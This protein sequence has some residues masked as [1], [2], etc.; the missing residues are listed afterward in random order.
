MGEYGSAVGQKEINVLITSLGL[1]HCRVIVSQF[2]TSPSIEGSILIMV[3]GT[4]TTRESS[5]HRFSQSFVLA[6]DGEQAYYVASSIFRFLKPEAE[7]MS[8]FQYVAYEAVPTMI[9]TQITENHQPEPTGEISVQIEQPAQP[10]NPEPVKAEPV[11]EHVEAPKETPAAAS[12]AAPQSAE[13]AAATPAP[14]PQQTQQQ[15]QQPQQT[16]Q[17]TQEKQ[18][19]QKPAQSQPQQAPQTQT[20]AGSWADRA[21]TGT[22]KWG[23]NIAP[24]KGVVV[25]TREEQ[26][27]EEQKE[28][29]DRRNN[30]PRRQPQQTQQTQQTQSD[31]KKEDLAVYVSEV[32]ESVSN[33]ELAQAFV[34]FGNVKKAKILPPKQG[35]GSASAFVDFD[36][37]ESVEKAIQKGTI[38]FQ[39]K[40]LKIQRRRAPKQQQDGKTVKPRN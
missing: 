17:P 38:E 4:I 23:S 32:P 24:T 13:P 1:E 11:Q 7:A 21:A 40:T 20:K 2:D 26:K 8:G 18:Q 37:T 16:Q 31:E 15:P 33:E 30:T 35:S 19:K 34:Q 25:E 27:N 36:S 6:K 5:F 9:Q 10:V 14:Q 29:N 22:Q 39:G 28:K 12:A 3:I